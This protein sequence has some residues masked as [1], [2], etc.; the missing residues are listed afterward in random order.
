MYI[1]S[2]YLIVSGE[3]RVHFNTNVCSRFCCT[4]RP[5]QAYGYPLLLLYLGGFGFHPSLSTGVCAIA[6]V[7]LRLLVLWHNS[8]GSSFSPHARQPDILFSD[9]SLS[10]VFTAEDFG[11]AVLLRDRLLARSLLRLLIIIRP[12]T[13]IFL[14]GEQLACFSGPFVPCIFFLGSPDSLFHLPLALCFQMLLRW[15]W[16]QPDKQ[17]KLFREE[18]VRFPV[19]SPTSYVSFFPQGNLC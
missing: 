10:P 5:F 12:D 16:S 4:P 11:I 6:A 3:H 14:T 2:N 17:R 19:S 13:P 1:S 7:Y 9:F 8:I 15:L 18:K